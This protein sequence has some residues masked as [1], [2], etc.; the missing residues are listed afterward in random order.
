MK[1]YCRQAFVNL[2]DQVY[3]LVLGHQIG[4]DQALDMLRGVLESGARDADTLQ[5]LADLYSDEFE[6]I[7]EAVK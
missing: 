7:S 6:R 2:A 3:G 4:V 1:R 5:D